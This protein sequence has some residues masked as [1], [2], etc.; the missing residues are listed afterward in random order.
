MHSAISSGS[1]VERREQRSPA[2][3][4]R[5]A[6]E[7][8]GSN[9]RATRRFSALSSERGRWSARLTGRLAATLSERRPERG[10]GEIADDGRALLDQC[11]AVP[12]RWSTKLNDNAA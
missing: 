6:H 2:L 3:R 7:R 5:P 12:D 1:S 4:W 11:A 8:T 9:A 10:V